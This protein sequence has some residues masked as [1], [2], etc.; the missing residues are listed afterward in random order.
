[1][2]SP[3]ALSRSVP[4]EGS[5][6]SSS[7][8]RAHAKGVLLSVVLGSAT[9]A[10]VAWA[11]FLHGSPERSLVV[12]VAC[13]LVAL[14][15]VGVASR[16]A[17]RNPHPLRLAPA[18]LLAGFVLVAVACVLRYRMLAYLP[19]PDRTGFEELQMGGDGY[20]VLTSWVLS[21]IHI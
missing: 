12:Q 16:E 15:W 20:N 4:R 13:M 9:L 19:L 6:K 8:R 1:M 18:D 5:E 10:T 7:P 11:E 3:K 17:W 21:L 2:T 14:L